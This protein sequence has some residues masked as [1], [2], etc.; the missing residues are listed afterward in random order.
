MLIRT[1]WSKKRFELCIYF[2]FKLTIE[3]RGTGYRPRPGVL[4]VKRE[5]FEQF[6]NFQI[7]FMQIHSLFIISLR[8]MLS[9]IKNKRYIAHFLSLNKITHNEIIKQGVNFYICNKNDL[10][11]M[12]YL[13]YAAIIYVCFNF[14]ICI[15]LYRPN[16]FQ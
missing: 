6:D 12:N 5:L 16:I 2:A 10:E 1:Q 15:I 14:V 9:K 4:H 7:L 3:N 11:I 13:P 8:A